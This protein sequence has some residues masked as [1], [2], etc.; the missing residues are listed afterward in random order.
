M[1]CTTTTDIS[2]DVSNEE[3]I[4]TYEMSLGFHHCLASRLVSKIKAFSSSGNMNFQQFRDMMRAVGLHNEVLDDMEA[5][6]TRF[7][8]FLGDGK[9][10]E[11]KKVAMLA[12][13]LGEGTVDTKA[14]L[15]FELYQAERAIELPAVSKMVQDACSIAMKFLPAYTTLEMESLNDEGTLHKLAS[16]QSKLDVA[17]RFVVVKVKDNLEFG[18]KK[19]TL[20]ELKR[21]KMLKFFVSAHE[22]R[23]YAIQ[24]YDKIPKEMKSKPTGDALLRG[25]QTYGDNEEINFDNYDTGLSVTPRG[26]EGG[27]YM[28][29]A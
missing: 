15:L 11:S 29:M 17:Y 19:V 24:L 21:S 3:L 6:V 22:A 2:S 8:G 10:L 16:Y 13:L 27:G 25:A 1:G 12:L 28:S 4:Q 23:H 26:G 14:E 7:Y 20:P 5:P 18:R 9:R